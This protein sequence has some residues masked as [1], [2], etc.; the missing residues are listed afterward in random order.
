MELLI[1]DWTVDE[2]VELPI[3]EWTVDGASNPLLCCE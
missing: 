2:V 3:V 1:V